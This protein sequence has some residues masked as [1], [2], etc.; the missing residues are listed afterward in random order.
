M[1]SI[2][3]IITI[4]SLMLYFTGLIPAIGEWYSYD[5]SFRLQTE[6]FMRGELALQPLPYGH[7]SDWV[8][9]NGIQ[10]VWGLGVPIIKLPFEII[11][12]LFGLFGFPDRF[13]FLFFYM[14]VMAVFLKS[15]NT[16]QNLNPRSQE[17]LGLMGS[18]YI[19]PILVFGFLN[20]AFITMTRSSFQPYEEVIA[21]GYLWAL[22]LFALLQIFIITR[23]GY[24]YLLICLLS[25]FSPCIRPTLLAYGGITFLIAFFLAK[26]ST[27]FRWLGPPVFIIGIIFLLVTNHLR[28]GSPLEFGHRLTL[29]EIPFT[30]YLLKFDNSLDGLSFVN[31]ALELFSALF[32]VDLHKLYMLDEGLLWQSDVLRVRELNFKPYDSI[33]LALLL[34]SWLMV[35]MLWIRNRK[36]NFLPDAGKWK[37]IKCGGLWSFCSFIMMFY[38]YSR[39]PVLTSR[40][41]VDF[42]PA[43]VVGIIMLYLC[44]INLARK[45]LPYR[46]SLPLNITLYIAFSGWVLSSVLSAKIVP[47]YQDLSKMERTNVAPVEIAKKK[48]AQMRQTEGPSLPAGY[49]CGDIETTYGIPYNNIGW[50][51][52][53]DCGVFWV[54]THFL[55]NPTC[56]AVHVEPVELIDE[57][58]NSYSDAEIKVKVGLTPLHRESEMLTGRGKIITYC[59]KEGKMNVADKEGLKLISIGWIDFSKHPDTLR[60]KHFKLRLPLPP[61]KLLSLEKVR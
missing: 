7:R 29:L 34:L 11:A 45:K 25:G 4:S 41:L 49:H 30:G 60:G 19:I 54:T 35:A 15:L 17:R 5:Q 8:W 3:L 51:A 22:M 1:M 57:R 26:D 48:V 20:P 43:I 52:A 13:I 16:A 53:T 28:F 58:L 42:G 44:A 47:I 24:L 12:K 33:V 31:A 6:A 36:G 37:L 23:K 21:Y 39:F 14:F 40:Y 18:I 50:K 59:P 61:I 27:K 2:I 46:V 9:G 10:Q 55:E 38:F 56:L 32:F